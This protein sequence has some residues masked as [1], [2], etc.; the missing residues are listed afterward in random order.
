MAYQPKSSRKFITGVASAALVAS[1]VA[2]VAASAASHGAIVKVYQAASVTAYKGQ[3]TKDAKIQKTVKVKYKDGKTAWVSV[4]WENVNFT[5]A[6]TKVVYGTVAGTKTKAKVNVNVKVDSV[7][8]V[9]NQQNASIDEGSTKEDLLKVL[10]AKVK[11]K[12]ASGKTQLNE[13]TYD[14]SKVDFTKPG[15]YKVTVHAAHAPAKLDRE[16]T[17]TVK[18]VDPVVKSVSAINAKEIVVEFNTAV[19]SVTAENEANYALKVAG[20]NVTN[21]TATVDEDDAKKVILTLADTAKLSNDD[22]VQLTV[23]KNI[24]SKNLNPGKEDYS[25]TWVFSDE[26]APKITKVEKDGNDIK[27]TFDDYVSNV[28]LAKVNGVDKTSSVAAIS[29][30]TKTITITNGAQGLVNGT[31]EVLLSG[32]TDAAGNVSSVISGSVTVSDDSV[33]PAVSKVEQISDNVLKVTFSKAITLVGSNNFVVKKNG[34]ALAVA[35]TTTDGGKTYTLTLSDASPVLVYDSGSDTSNVTLSVSGYKA[36]NN[37]LGDIYNTAITLSKDKTAP[38]VVSRFNS[39]NDIGTTPTVDEVFEIHFNEVITG[40]GNPSAITLTDAN[41]IR[42]TVNSATVVADANGNNTI[43][44]VKATAVQSTGAIKTGNYNI[45]LPAGFVT[46]LA[47]NGIAAT[48]VSFTKSAS[49]SNVSATASAVNNVITVNYGSDMTTSATNPANYMLDGKNLPAGTNVYFDTNTQTVKIEL[50]AGSV[51]STGGAVLTIADAVQS[52]TGNKVAS[53]NRTQN[54][55]NGFV[56][57]VKPVLL[58][59]K[60]LS[61]TQIELT[62]SENLDDSATFGTPTDADNDFVVKINGVTFAY[63]ADTG[64]GANDNKLVLTTTT[65]FNIAQTV[66]VSV[67]DNAADVSV[68]DG[69]N[70]L[71]TGTTVTAN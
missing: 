61:S 34:Y 13:A 6:G 42:Q 23:S 56:D 32:V 2:P 37:L 49:A 19:D 53:A 40:A 22:A 38:T 55:P 31:Y 67:T 39:I 1:A 10:P 16:I 43:L 29:A 3:S 68:T 47:G 15:D 5:K 17:V 48:K 59:A 50:P 21:F 14:L 64:S 60:K 69:A 33:A 36:A 27:V 18:A 41:G 28:T 44:R 63:N 12:L 65:A 11:V 45:N 20:S 51:K 24:L 66:T 25:K 58:S 4:K 70:L 71:T 54:I 7:A 62:F 52:T 9:N 30:L 26:V 57:N 8:Y 35:P 46:D